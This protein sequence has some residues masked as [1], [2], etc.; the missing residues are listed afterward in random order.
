VIALNVRHKTKGATYGNPSIVK[1]DRISL[2]LAMKRYV[3][4]PNDITNTLT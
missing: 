4:P 1:A 2:S 3:M